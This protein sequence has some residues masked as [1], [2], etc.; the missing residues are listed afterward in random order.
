VRRREFIS[1]I[2]GAATWPRRVLA[3]QTKIPV[4]GFLSGRTPATSSIPV[5]AFRRG[6]AELGYNEGKDYA[7][8]FRYT[9]GRYELLPRL[10]ERLVTAKVDI[11]VALGSPSVRAAQRATSR[12]PIV[13]AGTGDA[14]QSGL[15]AS[16]ARPG[17]N[18][19]GSSHLTSDV[20]AK[21]VQ[22]MMTILPNIS[23]IAILTNPGS[24]TRKALLKSVE[25]AAGGKS[26]IVIAVDARNVDE[27]NNGFA[28]IK[29]ERAQALLIGGDSLLISQTEEIARLAADSLLPS[30]AN[31]PEYAQAGGL[32]SYGSD[33]KDSY[34]RAATFVDKIIKGAKPADLPIEQPTKFELI[35]NRKTAKALGLEIPAS[36]LFTADEVIE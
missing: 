26:A 8:E 33:I 27:L 4:I 15:V 31:W 7:V 32:F 24:A 20:L 21:H 11:I 3:Q 29:R 9:E 36:L 35:I 19:T 2:G 14:V 10:A 16:L 28:K 18:T 23:R 13:I 12:I 22:L 30:S 17:G 34:R 1:L 5:D 25:Q 6:M